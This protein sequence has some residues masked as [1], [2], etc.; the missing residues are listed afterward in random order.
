MKV[1]RSYELRREFH[2][3]PLFDR[4]IIGERHLARLPDRKSPQIALLY[5]RPAIDFGS[6]TRSDEQ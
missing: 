3:R 4:E 1:P 5:A 6:G 2:R